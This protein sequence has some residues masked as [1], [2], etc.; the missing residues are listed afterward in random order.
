MAAHSVEAQLKSESQR[1]DHVQKRPVEPMK[2]RVEKHNL[3]HEP[4]KEWCELASP[5]GPDRISAREQMILRVR[6][7]SFLSILG[8]VEGVQSQLKR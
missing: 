2:Q 8:F 6:H 7:P 4:F 5:L 1:E 3:T